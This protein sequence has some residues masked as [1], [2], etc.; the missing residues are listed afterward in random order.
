MIPCLGEFRHTCDEQGRINIPSRFRELLKQEESQHLVIMKGFDRCVALYPLSA[1]KAFHP[2]LNQE[3]FRTKSK[4]RYFKRDLFRGADVQIPDTQ[5]RIQLTKELRAHAGI[6]KN[7]VIYGTGDW[8]EIWSEPV[9]DTYLAAGE[10]MG[11]TLEENALEFLGGGRDR[12]E[13]SPTGSG[14]V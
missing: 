1:W 14:I 2:R 3:D 13:P 6:S 10:V 7:V 11:G 5:G 12:G 8:L 9:F 4:A